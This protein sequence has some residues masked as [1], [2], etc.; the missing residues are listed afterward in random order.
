[1]RAPA[2]DDSCSRSSSDARYKPFTNPAWMPGSVIATGLIVLGW[3][4][5]IQTGRIDTIWPMFG[6]ANQL[7]A[8][9]AL[10]VGTTLIIKVG[11]ARYMWITLALLVFVAVNTL[12]GGFLSIRDNFYPLALER[13]TQV[14]GWILVMCTAI[15]LGCAFIILAAA[16]GR[17]VSLLANGR[18]A[19]P[20]ES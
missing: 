8:S 17:W 12:W 5:F 2:S 18:Q 13:A 6:V 7:L 19:V 16:I 15:M 20:A 14:Q 3:G 9:V 10:A 11:K 1:M 4:Y